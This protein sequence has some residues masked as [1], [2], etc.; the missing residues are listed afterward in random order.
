[1]LLQKSDAT[2]IVAMRRICEVKYKVYKHVSRWHVEEYAWFR[3]KGVEE[4]VLN[5]CQIHI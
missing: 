1:M 4:F 3:T 2:E 5:P